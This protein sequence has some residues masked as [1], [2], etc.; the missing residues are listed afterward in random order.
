M[1]FYV[2]KGI[3]FLD[4]TSPYT[5]P[6]QQGNS[7]DKQ[8]RKQRRNSFFT[9]CMLL[10]LFKLTALKFR[11]MVP[12]ILLYTFIISFVEK[13]VRVKCLDLPIA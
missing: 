5:N 12:T 7:R 9:A 4:F 2:E 13:E 1:L 11:Q 10:F 3:R 6:N 8:T